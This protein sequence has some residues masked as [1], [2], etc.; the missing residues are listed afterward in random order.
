MFIIQ[1]NL[2]LYK[3]LFIMFDFPKNVDNLYG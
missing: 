1:N 2:V 3:N